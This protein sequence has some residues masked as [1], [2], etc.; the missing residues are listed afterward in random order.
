MFK[1]VIETIR[2][3]KTLEADWDGYGSTVPN[4][5]CLD[6]AVEFLEAISASNLVLFPPETSLTSHSTELYWLRAENQIVV[7]FDS[8]NE[9]IEIT[10]FQLENSKL[11][12]SYEGTDDIQALI[13]NLSESPRFNKL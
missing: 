2:D 11:I 12:W 3:Y 7:V 6:K 9:E 1:E 10:A 4:S 13:K 5:L 8:E